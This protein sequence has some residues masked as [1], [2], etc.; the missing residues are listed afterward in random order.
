MR[1]LVLVLGD[2]LDAASSAFDGFD[3]QQDAVWMAEVAEEATHVWSSQPRIAMFLAG[4][5]Q[6]AGELCARGRSV[7]YRKLDAVPG[8][9]ENAAPAAGDGP[10]GARTL[11]QALA[12]DVAR[13]APARLVMTAP[14]EHRV[15]ESLRAT[16]RALAVPLEVRE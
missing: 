10:P 14:G 7:H 9:L 13:L 2:Q 12:A 4:M 6:F 3:P 1:S 11:A 16:A 15:L 8:R 5:R